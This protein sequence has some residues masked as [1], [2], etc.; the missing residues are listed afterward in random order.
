MNTT[1]VFVE[2]LV[3]GLGPVAAAWLVL[4]LVLHPGA[5]SPGQI[6][7]AGASLVVFVPALGLTYVLGI[8]VD[9]IADR[10][11]AGWA[12]KLRHRHFDS[13]DAYHDAR[14]TIVYHSEPMYRIRQYGRSRMR[15]CRGWAVNAVLLVLP[16][17]LLVAR[18]LST[19][20]TGAL[21]LLDTSLLVVFS[22][23]VFSWRVLADGEYRK[24]RGGAV[25]IRGELADRPAAPPSR[26]GGRRPE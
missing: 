8:V 17:N 2:L 9:R 5:V 13:D 16:A 15:I 4:A 26:S 1:N 6:I 12:A 25:F 10:L 19:G 20:R 22:G 11:F 23:T 21:L 3:I 24:I 14:R 7:D 18:V